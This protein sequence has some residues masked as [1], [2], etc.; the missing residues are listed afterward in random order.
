MI[1]TI[2]TRTTLH[3]H[4]PLGPYRQAQVSTD[5]PGYTFSTMFLAGSRKRTLRGLILSG[6][7][8]GSGTPG[9]IPTARTMLWM[10]AWLD[11]CTS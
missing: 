3:L 7:Q 5:M 4:H 10:V 8:Q 9:T 2:L 11:G 6:T 1:M